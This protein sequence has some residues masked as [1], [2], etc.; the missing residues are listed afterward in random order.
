MIPLLPILGV[1]PK[2]ISTIARIVGPGKG[3]KLKDAA[4]ALSEFTGD[5]K[6]NRI[7]PEQ[8]AELEQAMMQHEAEMKRL[9]VEER[10]DARELIR[11]EGR[12]EDPWVR[13]ARPTFLWLMYLVLFWNFIV[14][15]TWQFFKTGAP[16]S[17]PPINFPQEL[18]Y[19]FGTAFVGY[20]GFR[21]LDKKN[22]GK[23]S[24]KD[25]FK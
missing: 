10:K 13:R 14:L 15:G 5:V 21:S 20:T 1:L 25:L 23:G 17:Q 11:E 18:Y 12:S 22:G 7:P 16:I 2:A 3:N 24:I 6:A 19:L 9:D 4:D 8:M